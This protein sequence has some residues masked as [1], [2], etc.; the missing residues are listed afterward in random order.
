MGVLPFLKRKGGE[1]DGV[2][3]VAGKECEE[4][5]EVKLR[6]GCIVN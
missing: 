5:S 6:S 1:V 2:R 3:Y 4:K